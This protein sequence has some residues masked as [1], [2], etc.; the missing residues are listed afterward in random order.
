MNRSVPQCLNRATTTCW[1]PLVWSPELPHKSVLLE[2][3]TVPTSTLRR[4]ASASRIM[5]CDCPVEATGPCCCHV[6]L[7][8]SSIR[9]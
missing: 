4:S 8:S 1:T 2:L 3:Q 5:L 7:E 9:E 6:L